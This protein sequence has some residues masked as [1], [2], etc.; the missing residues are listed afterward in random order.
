[1]GPGFDVPVVLRGKTSRS[2]ALQGFECRF[3]NCRSTE[4]VKNPHV[5]TPRL[6]TAFPAE[7][8]GFLFPEGSVTSVAIGNLL[9]RRV[10]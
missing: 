7:A 2:K 10:V 9:V 3:T 6:R 8:D 5:V 4:L 1:M